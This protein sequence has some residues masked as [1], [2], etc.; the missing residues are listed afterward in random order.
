MGSGAR[1]LGRLASYVG[2]VALI[3]AATPSLVGA[4]PVPEEVRRE[5]D[6]FTRWLKDA[7][8]SPYRALVMQAIGNGL[9]LGPASADVPIPGQA[10]VR[11]E[12]RRGSPVLLEGGA[13]RPL[14]RNRAIT[15]GGRPLMTAGPTGRSVVVAYDLTA[16]RYHAPTY[17]P[18]QPAWRFTVKLV[19]AP[20][21][22][23]ARILAPDGIEI[24]AT[25]AGTVSV[26]LKGGAVS[27][28][29]LRLPAPD[30]E[31]SELEI[32]YRDGTNDRGSYPAGRFVSLVPGPDGSYTLDFN[33]SRN[34]FCAYSTVYPCPAP[35]RGNLIPAA[36]TAGEQYGTTH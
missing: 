35:W 9:T 15:L 8:T 6:E 24:E 28:R 27:L 7:P 13:A 33:R 19:P 4:Q 32:Y 5:R 23:S 25:E 1:L 3:V 36:V 11:I 22:G 16:P 17:F 18:Y 29:V 21:P 26:P 12:E 31:E 20:R 2:A 34:P 14:A 10:L 30:G